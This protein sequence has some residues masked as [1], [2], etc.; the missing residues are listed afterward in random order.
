MLLGPVQPCVRSNAGPPLRAGRLCH[1]APIS[2]LLL[3]PKSAAFSSWKC[4]S[5][6]A[7]LLSPSSRC[8]AKTSRERR[9]LAS[10]TG[11]AAGEPQALLDI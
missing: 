11:S 4:R 2:L 9:L 10:L 7:V 6:S 3:T 1:C 8:F 5:R